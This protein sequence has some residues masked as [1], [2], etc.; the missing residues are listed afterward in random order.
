MAAKLK[1]NTQ[2]VRALL[3]SPE[4]AAMCKRSADQ[5]AASCNAELDERAG[6]EAEASQG[7]RDRARAVVVAASE[8]AQNHDRKHRT[9]LTHLDAGRQ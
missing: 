2:A 9:L 1:L 6:F 5:I 8:H 4:V 3:S 7:R